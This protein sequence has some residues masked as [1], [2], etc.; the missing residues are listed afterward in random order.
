MELAPLRPF[1]FP[2]YDYSRIQ[3]LV[4]GTGGTGGYLVQALGRLLYGF[5]Q[6]AEQLAVSVC[7]VDGDR[8]EAHNLIR[9]HFLPPDIGRAKATVLA[10]R[11]GQIYGL[12]W[13]AVPTYLE[14]AEDVLDCLEGTHIL[15]VLIGCVDNHPT[16]KILHDAFERLR[17]GVYIDLGNDPM[18][19]VDPL[20]SGYS[21]QVVVGLRHHDAVILPPVGTV[22]P[23]I[24]TDTATP[25]PTHAC[26]VQAVSQP[27]RLIT[28]LWSAMTGLSIF[29]TL[30]ATRTIRVHQADF[31]A[32]NVMV[33]PQYVAIPE[34][35]PQE[36][37][38]PSNPD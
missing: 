11:F 23:D 9:Q 21:G 22:Y 19:P 5:A 4:I 15:P 18:D 13:S 32:F 17:N 1:T 7:L 33:R 3:C 6:Q 10:E 16:R 14:T 34:H 20:G 27:Q 38:I 24:L 36:M 25:H 26:G 35:D 2:S 28:N 29:N 30:L 37:V 31:N 12:A 8:V